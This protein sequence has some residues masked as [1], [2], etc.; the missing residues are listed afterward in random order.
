MWDSA[1]RLVALS[2]QL[3]L[4]ARR[5]PADGRR[6]R[7]GQYTEAELCVLTQ[8]A[9][10]HTARSFC[11]ERRV[12]AVAA[13]AAAGQTRRRAYSMPATNEPATSEAAP[14]ACELRRTTA[15]VRWLKITIGQPRRL[16]MRSSLAS[17]FTA[18]G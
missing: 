2:R 8:S 18:T 11:V 9:R 3:A 13:D 15:L 12:A 17:G 16:A 5:P 7:S 4:V 14:T 1:G 10:A 6:G